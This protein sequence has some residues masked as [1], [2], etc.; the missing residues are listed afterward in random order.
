LENNPPPDLAIEVEVSRGIGTRRSIY[1]DL[2]VPELWR[3]NGVAVTVHKLAGKE[4]VPA[5]ASRFFPKL[6]LAE[7]SQFVVRAI[8]NQRVVVIEYSDLLRS[9]KGQNAQ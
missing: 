2:G 4:Y 8:V 9:R 7:F 6:D 3:F 1:A 5:E